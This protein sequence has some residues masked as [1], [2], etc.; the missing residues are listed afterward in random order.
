MSSN[1]VK[2]DNA[3]KFHRPLC[4]LYPADVFKNAPKTVVELDDVCKVCAQWPDHT[5][6]S[7]KSGREPSRREAGD[8]VHRRDVTF[9]SRLTVREPVSHFVCRQTKTQ[10]LCLWTCLK[11]NVKHRPA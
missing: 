11:Q 6:S 5:E 3:K 8:G 1:S 10:N 4:Y 7:T 9:Q 2:L